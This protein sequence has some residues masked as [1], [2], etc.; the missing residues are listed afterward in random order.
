MQWLT[1]PAPKP[2]YDVNFYA[3]V[4]SGSDLYKKEEVTQS[5]WTAMEQC[6]A[7]AMTRGRC[8]STYA[9]QQLDWC[10][11]D[12][13][14]DCKAT[15][16]D[17]TDDL[18]H[19]YDPNGDDQTCLNEWSDR[20]T[21]YNGYSRAYT[22]SEWEFISGPPDT[23]FTKA[24][25]D[26][27]P[28]FDLKT[29]F[30]TN[31]VGRL[32]TFCNKGNNMNT[33]RD[34]L[35]LPAICKD[36]RPDLEACRGFRGRSLKD[37]LDINL[38]ADDP[39]GDG[40]STPEEVIANIIRYDVNN[41]GCATADE[42]VARWDS[43]YGFSAELA[44][45]FFFAVDSDGDNCANENDVR[46]NIGNGTVSS[47]LP[48][49]LMQVL[50]GVCESNP[51]LYE[52][53]ADCAM[54]VDTCIKYFPENP[55][56]QIYTTQCG[57]QNYQTCVQL[58]PLRGECRSTMDR[59]EVHLEALRIENQLRPGCVD[60]VEACRLQTESKEHVMRILGMH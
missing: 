40:F 33:N 59:S 53:N 39:N 5:C 1:Q 23:C 2:D 58:L 56:C 8:K 48:N 36:H 4:Q 7:T 37:K 13:N 50:V 14:V 26:A 28:D 3:L 30:S 31:S 12:V 49:G 32:V 60:H 43:L 11:N 9:A 55:G 25:L 19:F 15:K 21:S 54:V 41:D 24:S 42:F 34:C 20:R 29:T 10:R 52:T 51:A 17:F 22:D 57:A 18:K 35:G 27:F 44:N 47:F 45:A 16:I 38:E 6:A 46:R